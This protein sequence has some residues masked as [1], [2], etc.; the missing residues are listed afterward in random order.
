MGDFSAQRLVVIKGEA[1]IFLTTASSD[2]DKTQRLV[3]HD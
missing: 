2:E 1:D 3:N